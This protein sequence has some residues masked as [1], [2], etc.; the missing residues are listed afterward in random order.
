DVVFPGSL[1][2]ED[3]GVVCS[4]E[5][6]VLHIREAVEPLGNARKDWKVICDLADRLGH[7]E[8]FAYQTS[9]EIFNELREASRGGI[10]DY[11]GI[12]YEKIDRQMGVFWP[13][14]EQ[15]HPGTPRLFKGGRFLHPD[16]R[17]RFLVTEY[18]ES[19][20]PVAEDFPLYL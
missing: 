13:C 4:A 15:D 20:D 8:R 6:R 7:K 14:P 9:E 12:T 17:A 11:Y 18:R 10:A 19:G 16:G 1:H 2:E 5:G 3:E